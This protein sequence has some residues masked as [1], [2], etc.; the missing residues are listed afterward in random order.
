MISALPPKADMS[1]ARINVCS[2]PITD[3]Q[4][5][6][7]HDGLFATL[8]ASS[9]EVVFLWLGYGWPRP[10]THGEEASVGVPLGLLLYL[11][12]ASLALFAAGEV[13]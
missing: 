4:A 5:V 11:Q 2:V 10:N 6:V 1:G 3:I 12:Y 8:Q 7:W 13:A 9:W